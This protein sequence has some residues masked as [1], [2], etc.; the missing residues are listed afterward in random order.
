VI[1]SNWPALA[2]NGRV[3]LGNS[4]G[5]S[6]GPVHIEGPVYSL[7]ESHIHKS[8]TYES[9]Y[10]VGSEIADVIHNCQW[11]S[12]AYDPRARFTLG[13]S[14]RVSGRSALQIIRLEERP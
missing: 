4:C 6:G 13:L 7:A 11:F 9:S 12:F 2:A 1:F 8:N 10:A 5:S 3:K 14:G